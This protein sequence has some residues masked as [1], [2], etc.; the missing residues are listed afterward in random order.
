MENMTKIYRGGKIAGTL[1]SF[2][3]FSFIFLGIG[4]LKNNQDHL[5]IFSVFALTGSIFILGL[6]VRLLL[7]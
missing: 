2:C 1:F 3:V 7:K 4:Y 5:G 6:F